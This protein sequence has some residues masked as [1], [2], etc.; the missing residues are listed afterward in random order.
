MEKYPKTY[1][2]YLAMDTHN[3]TISELEFYKHGYTLLYESLESKYQVKYFYSAIFFKIFQCY[4]TW[5]IIVLIT[6]ST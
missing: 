3:T 2:D 4:N 6:G 5:L 1:D